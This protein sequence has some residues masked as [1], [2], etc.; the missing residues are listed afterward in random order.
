MRDVNRIPKVLQ[1]LQ[2]LWLL[3]PDQRFGQL[4]ENVITRE[5]G[6]GVNQMDRLES[7]LWNWEEDK[8]LK[9]IEK[10]K[11]SLHGPIN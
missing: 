2:E 6:I 4:I 8:W 10:V 5:L 9:A 11:E 7:G 3:V 1:A